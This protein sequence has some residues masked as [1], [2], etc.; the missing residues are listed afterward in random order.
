MEDGEERPLARW[1]FRRDGPAQTKIGAQ[2]T[3]VSG[4][5]VRFEEPA[6]FGQNPRP[7]AERVRRADKKG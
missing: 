3:L 5:V 1:G 4:R 6:M 2:F 7:G